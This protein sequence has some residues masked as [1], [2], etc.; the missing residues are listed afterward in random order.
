VKRDP[1]EILQQGCSI[2]D[3]VLSRWGFAFLSGASG[4]SSGGNF[5]SG[6]Y[7]NGNRKLEIHYRFSLGL[8]K[9]HFADQAIEHESYMRAVLGEKRENKYPGFS[10]EPLDA[11]KGLA[12][13]LENFASAFLTGDFEEFLR[14]VISQ[15]EWKKL[16][17]IARIP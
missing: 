4:K 13:D 9:Y 2:L 5:A 3:P 6:D 15:E 10:D 12:Y 16:P 14:Q 17:G 7:V 11:F 1:A 8:V